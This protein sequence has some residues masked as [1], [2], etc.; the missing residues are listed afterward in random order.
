MAFCVQQHVPLE[1][2]C[3]QYNSLQSSIFPERM[4]WSEFTPYYWFF[5]ISWNRKD[6]VIQSIKHT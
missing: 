3:L 2:V 4:S 6:Y 5:F 1:L